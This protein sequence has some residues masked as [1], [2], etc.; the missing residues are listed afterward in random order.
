MGVPRSLYSCLLFLLWPLFILLPKN[1]LLL[2][3][4]YY[5]HRYCY[6]LW[7]TF[8]PTLDPLRQNWQIFTFFASLFF[9]SHVQLGRGKIAISLSTFDFL[10]FLKNVT[11]LGWSVVDFQQRQG[12]ESGE[13]QQRNKSHFTLYPRERELDLGRRQADMWFFLWAAL[14]IRSWWSCT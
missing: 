5:C 11:Y 10:T 4:F 14:G 12:G 3:L 13:T 8:F 7:L 1:L 6:C 9:S 2:S